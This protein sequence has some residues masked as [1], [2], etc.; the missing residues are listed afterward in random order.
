MTRNLEAIQIGG[1]AR[2]AVDAGIH[3]S[4]VGLVSKGIFINSGD[5]II[6]LTSAGYKS[7][8]NIQVSHIELLSNNL[9][10]GNKCHLV[11]NSIFFPQSQILINLQPAKVWRPD[12]QQKITCS[13]AQ[14]T[15]RIFFLGQRMHDIDPTKGWLFLG[16]KGKKETD[17]LD[18]I[19]NLIKTY[20]MCFVE[21]FNR[22]DLSGG[23]GAAKSIIGLGGGLTPSG[24]DWLT[25]FMLLQT[26]LD[27]STGVERPFIVQSGKSL[28]ELAF[29]KTTKISANRIEAACSG[30]SEELFLDLINHIFLLETEFDDLKINLLMNFGHSSGV[31]TSMGIFAACS[32]QYL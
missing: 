27:Q 5:K 4:V 30:W 1:L 29:E 9:N 28:T 20:T 31:D 3:G 25:G 17:H 26:R 8:Y 15:E 16:D 10:I 23:L 7:P 19:N 12:P 14:Q 13:L 32:T 22:M 11:G 2:Q 21:A 18:S 24:D 6:F